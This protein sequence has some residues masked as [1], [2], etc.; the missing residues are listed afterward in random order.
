[1]ISGTGTFVSGDDEEGGRQEQQD[2][3]RVAEDS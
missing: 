1:M 3:R 2:H